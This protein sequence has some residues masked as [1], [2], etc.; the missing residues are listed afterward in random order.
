M[1]QERRREILSQIKTKKMISVSAL[2]ESL[3]YSESTIRRDLK[4]L[5]MDGLI[6]RTR[7]GAIFIQ[8]SAIEPLY[9]EKALSLENKNQKKEITRLAD[10]FLADDQ[11]IFVDSSS[12]C[13]YLFEQ[14]KKYAGLTVITNGLALAY[15]LAEKTDV[16]V[17]VIG[18]KVVSKRLTI[19][20]T[21]AYENIKSHST[22]LAFVSCRG[23]DSI[24]GASEISE[25]EAYVK[26]AC[27]QGSRQTILLADSSKFDK[28]YLYASLSF[29][30]ID[31]LIT[32]QLPTGSLKEK[33]ETNDI[34]IL[35]NQ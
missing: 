2:S 22:D 8:E 32:D 4:K 16:N 15:F 14:L 24:A 25:G 12:T 9:M 20:G 19:N 10:L 29:E 33:L 31:V 23:L 1:S 11:T 26:K 34:E 21:E 3:N 17:I 7:G 30:N 35:Q 5:D 27:S 6:R 18:G 28:G 13:L